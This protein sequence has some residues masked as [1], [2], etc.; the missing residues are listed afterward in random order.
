MMFG[1]CFGRRVER[2]LGSTTGIDWLGDAFSLTINPLSQLNVIMHHNASG[3][4][5][6]NWFYAHPHLG[7]PARGEGETLPA[8][9]QLHVVDGRMIPSSDAALGD[10]DGAARLP[11]RVKWRLLALQR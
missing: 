3:S 11:Y 4:A 8:S 7:P 10:G 5:W 6:D 9:L 2:G 1:K